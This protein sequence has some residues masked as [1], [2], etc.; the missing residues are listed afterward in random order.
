MTISNVTK[1]T[2]FTSNEKV[3]LSTLWVFLTANYIYCDVFTLMNPEDLKQLLTGGTGQIHITQSFLLAFAI[4]MEIPLAMI[5]LSRLL[6]YGVN[7]VVNIS[8]A[9]IMTVI[10]VWS[11]ISGGSTPTLH[12]I[13]FSIVEI[14]CL[15]FIAIYAWKWQ[16]TDSKQ[17]IA[18]NRN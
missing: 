1:K 3:W 14:A 15:V 2:G 10:Q 5:V 8:A 7:R 13:F 9:I 18:I 4:I 12:Y 16:N 11:L 17:D 6:N